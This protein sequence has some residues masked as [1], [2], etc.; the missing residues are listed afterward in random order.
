MHY[1]EMVKEYGPVYATWLFPFECFNGFLEKVNHN[2][3]D[4]S[5]METMLLRNWIHNQLIHELL[6]SL[7]PDAHLKEC[8]I[9]NCL[10]ETESKKRGSM[11]TQ[12]AIFH[13][14]VNTGMPLVFILYAAM[15]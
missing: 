3:R 4:G 8:E 14:E 6:I 2:R 5:K 9:I 13:S 15:L 10:V 7:P 11:M 12:I 1:Y